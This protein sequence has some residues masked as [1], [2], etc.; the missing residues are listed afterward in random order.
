MVDHIDDASKPRG[1]IDIRVGVG[2]RRRWSDE[3]KGRI[4]AE[5]YMPG[6]VVAV[7]VT[8]SSMLNATAH[9]HGGSIVRTK[10]DRR[11]MMELCAK[12]SAPAFAGGARE[13]L[14]FPEFSPAFD[15]IYASA[16]I[17]E[18]LARTRRKASDL[19]DA[20]PPLHLVRRKVNCP[21]ERK[22]VIMRELISQSRDRT[23]DLLDGV[24]IVDDDKWV[25]VLPDPSD[26][27]FTVVAE[28]G[29]DAEASRLADEYVERIAELVGA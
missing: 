12:P 3:A 24:K 7:P 1:R 17:L 4:V 10:A 23:L 22:G 25:L 18:L 15:A 28:A 29:D 5:S 8:A 16:K 2:R 19:I 26:P 11:S 13:G 21:W 20:V 6:A 14:I 27:L 9:E